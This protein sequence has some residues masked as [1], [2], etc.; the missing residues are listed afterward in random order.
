MVTGLATRP[1]RRGDP[2][3]GADHLVAVM[4][5]DHRA[6]IRARIMGLERPLFLKM[7]MAVEGK[8]ELLCVNGLT[9]LTPDRRP[10][11]WTPI[12]RLGGQIG[13]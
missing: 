2:S 11:F 7:E 4:L 6:A 9:K 13:L 1:R 5:L 3:P 12:P 10:R 8:K